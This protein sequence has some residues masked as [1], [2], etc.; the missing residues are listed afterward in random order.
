M[1]TFVVY[2]TTKKRLDAIKSA[3]KEHYPKFIEEPIIIKEGN[4]HE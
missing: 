4:S 3:V 2:Q 1:K